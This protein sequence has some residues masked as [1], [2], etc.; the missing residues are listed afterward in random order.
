LIV[1]PRPA[2]TSRRC[3]QHPLFFDALQAPL[4]KID[5]HRLLADLALQLRHLAFRPA[6]LT[7]TRKSASRS[8]PELTHPAVQ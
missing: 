8:L 1:S 3:L 2:R 5:L 4:Q 7:L 6:A